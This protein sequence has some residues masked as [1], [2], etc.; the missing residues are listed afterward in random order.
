MKY[1]L[2]I[3]RKRIVDEYLR[4]R[5][6]R[7]LAEIKANEYIQANKSMLFFPEDCREDC[8]TVT[9]QEWIVLEKERLA[10]KFHKSGSF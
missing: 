6:C 10:Q 7:K 9:P 3:S 1:A 4:Y 2:N 5:E 8:K